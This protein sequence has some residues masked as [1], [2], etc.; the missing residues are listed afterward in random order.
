MWGGGVSGEEGNCAEWTHSLFELLV[1]GRDLLQAGL[2]APDLPGLLGNGAVAGEFT[3]ACNV[4]DHHLGPFLGIL[5][6][7]RGTDRT[8]GKITRRS[9]FDTVWM[10]T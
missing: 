8:E 6:L 2:H 4:M 10:D 7:E 9:I 3:T 1:G 5:F